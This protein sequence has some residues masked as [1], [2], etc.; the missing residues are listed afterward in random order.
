[1]GA[2]ERIQ[3]I[4]QEGKLFR[5]WEHPLFNTIAGLDK[6]TPVAQRRS[7]IS[8]LGSEVLRVGQLIYVEY[9]TEEAIAALRSHQG[10][11]PAALIVNQVSTGFS[12]PPGD[13][14]E[15]RAKL[16]FGV[17]QDDSFTHQ[18]ATVGDITRIEETVASAWRGWGAELERG[19]GPEGQDTL[20]V[21]LLPGYEQTIL[22]ELE[23]L[24][25]IS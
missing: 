25:L 11:P 4:T 12:L 22:T 8:Q 9:L 3:N 2:L 5:A 14:T 13:S 6:K 19:S 1:M 17:R 15:C 24:P 18:V 7:I 23:R 21:R 16:T 20:D 10:P